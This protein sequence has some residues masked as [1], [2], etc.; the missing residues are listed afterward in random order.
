MARQVR[1]AQVV[2]IDRERGRVLEVRDRPQ[3]AV[4]HRLDLVGRQV[5]ATEQPTLRL[6][7]EDRVGRPVV[8]PSEVVLG[9]V[10]AERSAEQAAAEALRGRH[11]AGLA[12]E[13]ALGAV[14][15]VAGRSRE[16]RELVRARD[17][18]L[19]QVDR[20]RGELRHLQRLERARHVL[21]ERALDHAVLVRVVEHAG[22]GEQRAAE[23]AVVLARRERRERAVAGREVAG[24]RVRHV[25]ACAA[26]LRLAVVLR[27]GP[28]V[29]GGRVVVGTESLEPAPQRSLTRTMP[30]DGRVAAVVGLEGRVLLPLELA[31]VGVGQLVAHLARDAVEVVTDERGTVRGRRAAVVPAERG[32][33]AQ[34]QVARTTEVLLRDR[35]RRP[36]H[37]IAARVGHHA[38]RPRLVGAALGVVLAVT[39][40]AVRARVEGRHLQFLRAG[41]AHLVGYDRHDQRGA[42]EGQRAEREDGD[43]DAHAPRAAPEAREVHGRGDAPKDGEPANPTRTRWRGDGAEGVL[44]KQFPCFPGADGALS[45]RA[46]AAPAST[47]GAPRGF[48]R[49]AAGLTVGS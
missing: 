24:D 12:G 32:V 31:V 30:G 29:E 37:R 17:R 7:V 21:A 16:L 27:L 40:L 47:S 1:D 18:A 43:G 4:L 25:V 6:E 2:G 9:Q 3:L 36:E 20:Q 23:R 45:S 38:A 19:A 41:Q 14:G 28:R 49:R 48:R 34:A 46:A 42:D 13:V 35:D 26:Q 10:V 11:V 44:R 33:T 15:V 5:V 39:H 8:A 22:L